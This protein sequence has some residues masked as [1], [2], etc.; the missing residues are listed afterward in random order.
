MKRVK[1]IQ[2]GQYSQ[3]RR[4]LTSVDLS[5]LTRTGA[6]SGG[7][8]DLDSEVD[9]VVASSLGLGLAAD[10]GVDVTALD[11]FGAAGVGDPRS[12]GSAS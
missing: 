8:L 1:G 11:R 2:N 10:A 4:D 6:S 9:V 3:T 7:I 5:T 12:I